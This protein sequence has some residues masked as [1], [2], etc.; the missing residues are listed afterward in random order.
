M[1]MIS[2]SSLRTCVVNGWTGLPG[3][4]HRKIRSNPAAAIKSCHKMIL[5]LRCTP[6]RTVFSLPSPGKKKDTL[7]FRRGSF[8]RRRRQFQVFPGQAMI[9]Q[10][11]T[12]TKETPVFLNDSGEHFFKIFHL[13]FST[14]LLGHG[15]IFF[16]LP[17]LV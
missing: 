5:I 17:G 16:R 11:A 9:I 4:R 8:F 13:L 6:L 10:E 15:D 14:S 1:D 2:P 7:L 12:G 3:G